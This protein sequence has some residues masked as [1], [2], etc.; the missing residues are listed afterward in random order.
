MVT[1]NGTVQDNNGTYNVSVEA[2]NDT[3]AAQA[4]F[5][6][7]RDTFTERGYAVMQQNSTAWSGF[8]VSARMGAAVE[9]GSSPLIPYYCM[10][11]TGGAGASQAPFQ[12]TMWQHM[13]DEMHEHSGNNGGLGPFMGYG[14]NVNTR[15]Q[16]QQEMQQHMGVMGQ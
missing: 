6:S 10:A 4:H 12:Q 7:L 14:M 1:Y 13:L 8:N 16:M 11:M 2:F 5:L 3:E 9:Y 15:S